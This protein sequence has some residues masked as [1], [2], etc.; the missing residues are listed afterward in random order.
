MLRSE[1][2][3]HGRRL[4][5]RAF[6]QIRPIWIEVGV[7]PRTHGSSVFT[8]GETQ[9]LVTAT[10][11][12]AEDQQK[13]E[14]VDGEIYKRFMLHYNFPPFSVGEVA[15]LRGPGRREVGHGAL[16]ERA[17]LPVIPPEETFPVHRPRRLGHPRIERLVVDG[18]RLRRDDGHDG[19]RRPAARPG[20]RHRD[21]PGDGRGHR[22]AR[23][24]HRHRR[25]RGS[26][27]R[28]GL[29]G[30]GDRR[31]ASRRSRWTSRSMASPPPSCTTRWRKPGAAVSRFWTRC[32]PR[33]PAPR[34]HLDLRAPHRDDHHPG[35]QDP[36]RDRAGRQ[37]DPR[38]HRTHG[39]QDRRRGRR[40]R[41][42]RVG[43]RGIGEAG[44][45]D[46]PGAHRH[47]RAQQV[48]PR[49][50]PAHHRLRGVRRDHARRGRPASR[51]GDRQAPGEGSAGRADRRPADHGQGHQHRPDRQGP[52]QPEGVARRRGGWRRHGR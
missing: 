39:R 25:R 31:R 27:R 51:V 16:A 5:G 24:A 12:T 21:G 46:H 18:Q 19:R 43:R 29:Q 42:R 34:E 10:L 26:L 28:H 32:A 8:R 22:P 6:D 7:L 9:A 44:D 49:H 2:L 35:R 41:Q 15:F 14:M 4:D 20:R 37:G 36:R 50:G 30:G 1:V 48:L 23:R 38:H 47:G 33:W 11:G 40:A 3:E 52:A 13:I 17:L 45:R